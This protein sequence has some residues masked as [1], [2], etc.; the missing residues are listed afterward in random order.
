MKVLLGLKKADGC[1]V[2]LGTAQRDAIVVSALI[3]H[4]LKE[5]DLSV[6]VANSFLRLP[7]PAEEVQA[8]NKKMPLPDE[9]IERIGERLS[10]GRTNELPMMWRLLKGTGMLLGEAF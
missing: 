2:A 10:G 9:P 3:T 5:Y 7:W 6:E 8:V 4:G 1:P